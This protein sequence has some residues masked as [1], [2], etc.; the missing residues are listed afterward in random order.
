MGKRTCDLSHI[1][2]VLSGQLHVVMDA[3]DAFDLEPGVLFDAGPGHDSWVV[4]SDDF[5]SLHFTYAGEYGK[6]T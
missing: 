6:S 4:G 5:V 3:G 1:G 2:L